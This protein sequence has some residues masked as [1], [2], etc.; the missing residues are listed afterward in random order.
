MGVDAVVVFG[1]HPRSPE[2]TLHIVFLALACVIAAGSSLYYLKTIRA[3]LTKP[4]RSS[5]WIWF[6]LGLLIFPSYVLS[7]GENWPL[8]AVNTIFCGAIAYHSI[9]YGE[10]GSLSKWDWLAVVIALLT[11]PAWIALAVTLPSKEAAL[12]VFV[13]QMI[14]DVFASFVIYEKA[15]NRPENEDKTAWFLSIVAFAFNSL[16]VTDW[17]VQNLFINGW[18]GG[19]AVAITVILHFRPHSTLAL[20]QPLPVALET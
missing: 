10:G 16:A 12:P 14:A 1:Y 15:W 19:T 4:S 20:D 6:F 5:Y 13:V 8:N 2:I 18:M 9:R 3:G 7:G 11:I 17:N